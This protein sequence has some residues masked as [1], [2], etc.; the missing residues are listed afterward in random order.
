MN[1]M[2]VLRERQ[3]CTRALRQMACTELNA[4]S[5]AERKRQVGEPVDVPWSKARSHTAM[6]GPNASH[7]EVI[8]HHLRSAMIIMMLTEEAEK[9]IAYATFEI[10]A[11]Y[12]EGALEVMV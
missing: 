12:N 6:H 7:Q 9:A 5:A 3:E 2:E 8:E 1:V 11:L 10:V 4:A